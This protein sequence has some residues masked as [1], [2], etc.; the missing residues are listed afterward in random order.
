MMVP[1]KPYQQVVTIVRPCQ[2][3]KVSRG[4]DGRHAC[5]WLVLLQHGNI[6]LISS[7]QKE[8]AVFR[9]EGRCWNS[10]ALAAATLLCWHVQQGGLWTVC[11][12]DYDRHQYEVFSRGP[13]LIGTESISS[14]WSTKALLSSKKTQKKIVHYMSHRIFGRMYGALNIGKK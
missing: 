5:Q 3:D 10:H 1:K 2:H 11:L 8:S 4:F 12:R 13:E 7:G 6:V 9:A 14:L